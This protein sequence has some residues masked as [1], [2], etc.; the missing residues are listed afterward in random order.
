MNSTS[1]PEEYSQPAKIILHPTDFSEDSELA[2][3]H[4]LRVALANQAHLALFHVYHDEKSRGFE[5]FP[6]VRA[7]LQRW[8]VL[9]P[10]ASHQD[11]GDLGIGIEK[12]QS[13]ATSV[14]D[15][16]ARFLWR[17]PVDLLV[18]ATEGRRGLAVALSL[19]VFRR[20]GLHS[21]DAGQGLFGGRGTRCQSILNLP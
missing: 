13:S 7:T 20:E 8:G 19:G 9:E 17:R 18:M 2:F 14:V 10:G 16:V 4:A 3:A 12:I 1:V 21:W 5:H 6:S 15:A 11:V